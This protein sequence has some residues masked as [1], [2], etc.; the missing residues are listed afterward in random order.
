MGTTSGELQLGKRYCNADGPVELL[1]TKPGSGVLTVGGETLGVKAPRRCPPRTEEDD[2]HP[3]TAGDR[4][5]CGRRRIALG[6]KRDGLSYSRCSSWPA[7]SPDRADTTA[8]T[9]L[10]GADRRGGLPDRTVGAAWAGIRSQPIS[11]RWPTGRSVARGG[12]GAGPPGFADGA[13][14]RIGGG[15]DGVETVEPG[16]LVERLG[17]AV[18]AEIPPADQDPEAP[19]V[20]LHTSGTTGPP[21]IA[22]I[23]VTGTWLSYYSAAPTVRR[24][25]DEA[26]L[27]S[28]PPY[29]S[30]VS[31]DCSQVSTAAAGSCRCRTST[32][33]NG[34]ALV[35]EQEITHAMVVPTMLARIVDVLTEDGG[36]LPSLRHLSYG[37]GAA[38]ALPVIERALGLLPD[39]DFVNGYGLTE[40]SSSVPFSDLPSTVPQ[41]RPRTLTSSDGWGR[42][43]YGSG[44]RDRGARRRPDATLRRVSAASC[45]C[46]ARR[47]RGSTPVPRCSTP[48]DGSGPATAAD[49]RRGIRLRRGAP[50]RRDRP[51]RGE[52]VHPARSRT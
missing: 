25:P 38:C 5:R 27:V 3:D 19:A 28:V 24:G 20:L 50:R 6:D 26:A 17:A 39:V 47:C 2:E 22:S 43:A 7:G 14:A 41:S 49:R 30:Q 45:G 48:T 31:Q 44:R 29:T 42:S 51:W 40:T 33:A 36:G 10:Y 8:Q 4:R 52:P 16:V 9:V 11:Y 15:V 12:S 21:K 37:G 18:A 35:R 34:C 46:G 23:C 13:V 32:N 1:C